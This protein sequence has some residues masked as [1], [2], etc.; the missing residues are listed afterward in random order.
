MATADMILTSAGLTVKA[1]ISEGGV[2]LVEKYAPI[3]A[4][5]QSAYD[6]SAT[7]PQVT[8][9]TL[10]LTIKAASGV[11][12]FETKTSGG[13]AAV[14]ISEAGGIT[15]ATLNGQTP[16]AFLV[17]A[18]I[19]GKADLDGANMTE[20]TFG[21]RN[22]A[23][24]MDSDAQTNANFQNGITSGT[25][26]GGSYLL[27]NLQ[28]NSSWGVGINSTTSSTLNGWRGRGCHLVMD[29]RKGDMVMKGDTYCR[30]VTFSGTLN[31]ISAA[32]F[33]FLDATSSIQTQIG[34]KT[35]PA[36]VDAQ[37]ATFKT[38]NYLDATS[39]IQTQLGAITM[40]IT[41]LETAT[42]DISYAATTTTIANTTACTILTLSDKIVTEKIH[43]LSATTPASLF[44]NVTGAN[45][46]VGLGM[47]TGLLTLGGAPTTVNLAT[48]STGTINIGGAGITSVN[49]GGSSTTTTLSGTLSGG[50]IISCDRLTASDKLTFSNTLNDITTTEFYYLDGVTGNIQTQIA[51]KTS[52]ADVDTKLA[53]F[54]TTNYLDATSSIQ[55]QLDTK[56]EDSD[57]NPY[58]GIT[59]DIPTTTTTIANTLATATA[60]FSATLNGI[61]A[62]T[63]AYLSG[64]SSNIQ[65]QLGFI[66]DDITDLEIA[67]TGLSYAT[68]T[69]TMLGDLDIDTATGTLDRLFISGNVRCRQFPGAYLCN[70]SG[71]AA[72]CQPIFASVPDLTDVYA[73]TPATITNGTDYA[74]DWSDNDEFWLILP[75]YELKV[76]DATGGGGTIRLSYNNTTSRTNSIKPTIQ[77]AAKSC[78]LYHGGTE[79][80]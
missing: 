16:G 79:I 45:I 80:D 1:A 36:A 76:Y 15:C 14:S 73:A 56:L 50:G 49:I 66:T 42:T 7:V 43:S 13:G 9:D 26:D 17:A 44:S 60:T 2:S 33:A 23:T 21:T 48:G 51:G 53:T 72:F 39:S 6:N 8:I 29:A 40:D 52:P 61:T 65:A 28:I 70:A 22:T 59:Y 74:V 31:S 18:D 67:T 71:K 20:G 68:D 64:V 77:N 58:T 55:T 63:F 57:L 78:Y 5:L 47:T 46:S 3:E 62:A 30:N 12:A 38:T 24:T 54:K 34:T 4:N 27:N 10:P 19:S 11:N 35:T 32:N 69:T 37:L 75:G 41:D 25:G